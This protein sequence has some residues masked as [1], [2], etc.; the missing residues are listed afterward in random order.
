M[1]KRPTQIS[2]RLVV[3]P[4]SCAVVLA[5]ALSLLVGGCGG[6]ALDVFSS[7]SDQRFAGEQEE[8]LSAHALT[9]QERAGAGVPPV[10]WDAPAAQVAYEHSLYQR[11][12]G[13]MT[14]AGPDGFGVSTRMDAHGVP[15]VLVGENVGLGARDGAGRIVQAWMDSEA[16]RRNLLYSEWTHMG[17]G[18]H[19]VPEG[20]NAGPWWTQVFY[21]PE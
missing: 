4:G 12:I 14:H 11:S 21:Y 17:L 6:D 20:P 19:F 9:N 7:K 5:L 18:V 15:Y 3:R 8:A 10:I 1:T 2:T 13:T 16:H